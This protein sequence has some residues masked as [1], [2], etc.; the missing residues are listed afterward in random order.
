MKEAWVCVEQNF[1]TATCVNNN[2]MWLYLWPCHVNEKQDLVVAMVGCN[3]NTWDK[4]V[5][6]KI[7]HNILANFDREL[8]MDHQTKVGHNV[9]VLMA[10]SVKVTTRILLQNLF[11]HSGLTFDPNFT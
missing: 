8:T 5:S 11:L 2:T 1:H 4:S 7:T 3:W 6:M 10:Y 9:T